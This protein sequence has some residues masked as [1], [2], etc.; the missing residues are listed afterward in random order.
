MKLKHALLTL[1]VLGC[2]WGGL[3]VYAAEAT[4]KFEFDNPPVE[5][6][7]GYL[8]QPFG[9]VRAGGSMAI[10]IG[11][12]LTYP[13]NAGGS[14]P[15]TVVQGNAVD[16]GDGTFSYP[17]GLS[18]G[19]G[20]IQD[21]G[22]GNASTDTIDSPLLNQP[23]YTL[24]ARFKVNNVGINEVA[25]HRYFSLTSHSLGG[26]HFQANYGRE[27]SN[28]NGV[29][30]LEIPLAPNFFHSGA[31]IPIDQD[32]FVKMRVVTTSPTNNNRGKIDVY[33]DREDGN[34]FVLGVSTNQAPNGQPTI[35]FSTDRD[36]GSLAGTCF[37]GCDDDS[38]VTVDYIRGVA[39]SL[40]PTEALLAVVAPGCIGNV[41]GDGTT[42]GADVAI[43]YNAW[44][45]NNPVADITKDGIVDGAD[46]AEVFNC[47]GQA[48][49]APNSV[50]EPASVGVFALGLVSL[51]A[52]RRRA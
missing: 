3:P 45:T 32:R 4:F 37:A 47:W 24:E 20:L 1:A 31:T 46:L 6:G 17:D 12:T 33:L 26:L 19:M 39:Q 23:N 25:N 9:N 51:L 43:I 50:P 13:A 27:G 35:A 14:L 42:D 8:I 2:F 10:L 11:E 28:G 44:G 15:G 22:A 40:A 49:I 5:D 48:D 29:L 52:A 7:A 16:N 41:N 18:S 21:V 30:T 34:G 38:N 36:R